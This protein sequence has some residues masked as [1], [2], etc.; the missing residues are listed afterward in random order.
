MFSHDTKK[1]LEIIKEIT[2]YTDAEKWMKGKRCGR[3]SMLTFQNHYDVKSEGEYRKQVDKYDLKTLFYRN[4][5]TLSFEKYVT[6]M[7]QTFNVLD[8]YNVPLY[9]EDKFRQLLDNI[10][11]PKND[12]KTEVN[13][14]RYIHSDSFEKASTYLSRVIS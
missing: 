10:N 6:N 13:I 2:V 3:E 12:F 11:C 4:E 1:V 8:N 14:C 5:T 7:K 9:E